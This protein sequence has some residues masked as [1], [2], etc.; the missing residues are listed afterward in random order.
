MSKRKITFDEIHEAGAKEFGKHWF[1]FNQVAVEVASYYGVGVTNQKMKTF[2]SGLVLRMLRSAVKK[3]DD[4]P[5][6]LSPAPSILCKLGSIAVHAE[7]YLSA[8]GHDYDAQAIL[9]GL[10]DAQLREWFEQMN[11]QALLPVKRG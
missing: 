9:S 10:Q 8:G 2:I 3:K 4:Q 6:P 5:D 1:A 11:A 7:E